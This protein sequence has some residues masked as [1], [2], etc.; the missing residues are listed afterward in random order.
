MLYI[1]GLPLFFFS[2]FFPAQAPLGLRS[3]IVIY[4]LHILYN[5]HTI[6]VY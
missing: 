2:L 1:Q 6:I 5:K 4:S 3:A